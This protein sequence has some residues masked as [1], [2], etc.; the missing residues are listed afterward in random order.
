MHDLCFIHLPRVRRPLTS[1][2]PTMHQADSVVL[3]TNHPNSTIRFLFDRWYDSRSFAGRLP[4]DTFCFRCISHSFWVTFPGCAVIKARVYKS[5][6]SL[7]K[8]H[9]LL[10][11]S[12]H[13]APSYSPKAGLPSHTKFHISSWYAVHPVFKSNRSYYTHN[14]DTNIAASLVATSIFAMSN[15]GGYSSGSGV[16]ISSITSLQWWSLTASIK[17]QYKDY[18][19]APAKSPY[20]KTPPPPPPSRRKTPPPLSPYEEARRK[21]REGL[22]PWQLWIQRMNTS[23]CIV[24][25][26]QSLIL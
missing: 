1:W 18:N 10:T 22:K 20:D 26:H 23:P 4:H 5:W 7:R 8:S 11:H 3:W 15:Q 16:A 14:K 12:H 25:Q 13:L 19:K 6:W 24:I 21:A 2:T 9:S 17:W